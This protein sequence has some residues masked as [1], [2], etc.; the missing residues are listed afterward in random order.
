[1]ALEVICPIC[2]KAF[3]SYP[4]WHKKFCSMSCRNQSYIGRRI[5]G[6]VRQKMSASHKGIIPANVFKPGDQHPGWNPNREQVALTETPEYKALALRVL[7]RDN[8]A[9]QSCGGR[10][11]AGYRPVLHVHHIKPRRDYPELAL[12]ESNCQTLCLDCHRK[13]DSYLSRWPAHVDEASVRATRE[14]A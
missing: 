8:Y 7:A 10:G 2:G 13:T 6:E 1:M 3:H 11:R 12:D 9:C 14:T 5:P 4:S